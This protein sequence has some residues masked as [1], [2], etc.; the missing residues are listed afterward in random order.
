MLGNDSCMIGAGY[1]FKMTKSVHLKGGEPCM[2]LQKIGEAASAPRKLENIPIE[3]IRPNP[4]QPRKAFRDDGIQELADSIRTHGI[5]Q[6]ITVRRSGLRDYELVAGERRLRAA[7]M[8]GMMHIE[9]FVVRAYDR[10][11]AILALIENLQRENLHFLEEAEA[12]QAAIAEHGLTQEELARQLGRTQSAVANKLRILRLP[13]AMRERIRREGL[14]ERHARALLRIHDLPTQERVLEQICAGSLNVRDSE[15]LVEQ[16]VRGLYAAIA[17]LPPLTP[18]ARQGDKTVQAA[19][20][21]APAP[22]RKGFVRDLRLYL[23]SIRSTVERLVR[24]GA[25]VKMQ[26]QPLP[27]GGMR[28]IIDIGESGKS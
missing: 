11:S 10:D 20:K 14:S 8:A 12:C 18:L 26:Q 2:F 9:A 5:L 19:P 27:G 15:E 25:P 4:Y 24:A 28:V 16:A 7:R 6:P 3:R 1:A 21:A 13:Q 23:N 22:V 17:P